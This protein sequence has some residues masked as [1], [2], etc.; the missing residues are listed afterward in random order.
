MNSILLGALLTCRTSEDRVPPWA[1]YFFLGS[2]STLYCPPGGTHVMGHCCG[3]ALSMFLFSSFLFL[4]SLP[5]PEHP[6]LAGCLSWSTRTPIAW[7]S[8]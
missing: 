1:L 2:P 5:S 4:G 6:A 3:F 7:K 8:L